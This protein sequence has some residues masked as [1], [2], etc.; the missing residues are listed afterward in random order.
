MLDRLPRAGMLVAATVVTLA[1]TGCSSSHSDV[2]TVAAGTSSASSPVSSTH[3]STAGV[4]ATTTTAGDPH[5]VVAKVQSWSHALTV[6]VSGAKLTTVQVRQHGTRHT[7]P[8]S[9]KTD[10]VTWKSSVL[11]V[12]GS[13]YDVAVVATASGGSTRNLTASVRITQRPPSAQM[14]YSVTPS[15]NWTVGVNAPIVIRFSNSVTRKASVEQALHVAS[16]KPVV[17]AWHWINSSEVHFRPKFSW[18]RHIKVRLTADLDGVR[19]NH[20]RYG[21]KDTVITFHVGDAHLTRVNGKTHKLTVYVNGKKT[22]VWPTSLGRPQF[23]TRSGRYIV[24]SKTP[25]IQ[26]TSC[27]AHITCDKTNPNYYDLTV[28]WDTRLTWSGTFIHAAPW[29]VAHQGVANV[30]HGC[31]NLSTAR[32]EAYYNIAQYGD[33]VVVTNTGRDPADLIRKGDPG[34]T[35]W[36]STWTQWVKGS[37][38]GKPVTTSTLK[39]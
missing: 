5:L 13:L 32:G 10:G 21:A 27:S 38:L 31:I 37:A 17:G 1:L 15:G 33:L 26:M 28:L 24:L 14:G 23:A 8:G 20:T 16:S 36:N 19:M 18:P 11:P 4:S 34:M 6:K 29:S 9:I 35:D 39:G 2:T 22:Y 12:A 30:S 25:T 7:L 3:S